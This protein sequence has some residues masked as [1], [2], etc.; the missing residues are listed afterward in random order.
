MTAVPPGTGSAVIPAGA[1]AAVPAASPAG[2]WL[3]LDALRGLSMLL[4]ILVN[5]PGRWG[6]GYQYA[7]L[8]HADWHGCTPTDLVFPTF[9]FCAGVAIVP[10]FDKKRAAG[11]PRLP[12]LFGIGKRVGMLCLLGLLLSAFP[13]LT[14]AAGKALFEPLLTVRFPGVLQRI[15][16][17]YGLAAL[18]FL[19]TPVLVQRCVLVL[20]LLGYQALLLWPLPSG[21]PQDLAS[22]LTTLQGVVDRAVFGEHIWK[23][24][25]YDPEGLL[26]TIPAL[27]T[28]MFGVECGRVLRSVSATAD[29]VATL[30]RFGVVWMLLGACWSWYLPLNKPLWTSSYALWT[31][32]IAAAG[33]G[34][35]VYW[36]E[37]RGKVR[38]ARPLQ[39][40]GTNALL[41]FV[42]SGL[43]ARTLDSL[44]KFDVGGKT[45]SAKDWFF[46]HALL[47]P[48]GDPHLASLLFGCLWVLGWYAVLAWLYRRGIVWK[49]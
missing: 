37:Q 17:C 38:W 45:Q 13:L 47:G 15:G 49:V 5:N 33:L 19:C 43:L 12:L 11:L 34:L 7:P 25:Q 9:L 1:P 26:S 29:K 16:I 18:L 21:A 40:Y 23:R 42:G 2:R 10:A 6:A 48:I 8:R 31:A 35:C 3:G 32:G 20:C 39:V 24:G 41:V 22:P 4:M 44:W 27:A 30:L 28:A 14:F 46:Q 36:C